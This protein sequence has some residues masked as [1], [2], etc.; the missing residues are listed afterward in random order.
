MLR[1]ILFL[2]RWLGILVGIIMTMWCLSGFVMMYSDYPRLLPAEQVQGLAPLQLPDARVWPEVRLEPDLR[3][4]AARVEMMAGRPVLRITPAADPARSIAQMRAA[5]ASIDLATAS[6]IT[7]LSAAEA[8]AV[9]RSFGKHFGIGGTALAATPA[10][11]DQWTVQTFRRHQP[12]HRIDYSDGATAYVAASGEIVQQTT[13]TERFWG[14]LGAVPHWL[15]PTLLRQ[16]GA[17]WSQVVIWASLLG[18]FL[19]ITGLW[20]GVARLRRNRHGKIKSAYRGLWWWHHMSGLL[21]GILTLGWVASGLLSMNPWGVLDSEAGFAERERLTTPMPW[22]MVAGALGRMTSLPAG[23]VRLE[24]APLGGRLFFSAV[25]AGGTQTR[26]DAMGRISPLARPELAA[27]LANGP[28]IESLQL[29]DV[30]DAYYYQHKYPV[31]LP[32]WRAVLRDAERTRLYIDSRTGRLLRAFDGNARL[33][34]W[35]QHGLHSF[36]FP[37]L[38]RRPLWDLVILPLLIMVTLVCA[39]GTSMAIAKACRDLRRLHNRRRRNSRP[40]LEGGAA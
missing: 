37:I 15:Y 38:R 30:E 28:P 22:A 10:G 7:G 11:I 5:P 16:D 18:C 29:I 25:S 34:R 21:F 32:V 33:F 24:I 31:T 39:T 9:G 6:P 8:L 40:P 23:T 13:R 1:P 35:L 4:S 36:D 3:L 27:A 26:I 17:L 2:H 14:W 19:T 12:L 20:V